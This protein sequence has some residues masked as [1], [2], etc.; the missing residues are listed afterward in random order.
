MLDIEQIKK[1]AKLA[2]L[3]LT[4]KQA[5][6][7]QQQINPII[8]F[9]SQLKEVD[10][11]SVEP[12]S[13]PDRNRMREDLVNESLKMEDALSNSKYVVNN[14]FGVPSVLGKAT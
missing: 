4:E 6:K 5:E 1:L 9:V 3:R 13:F 14:G 2:K 10:V 7:F 8:D 11:N 12:S